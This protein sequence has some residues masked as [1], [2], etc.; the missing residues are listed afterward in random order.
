MRGVARGSGSTKAL[1][2]S[3]FKALTADVRDVSNSASA[4]S[5]SAVVGL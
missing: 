2:V 5:L 1:A 3:R 4:T